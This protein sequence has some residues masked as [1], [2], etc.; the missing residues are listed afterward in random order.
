MYGIWNPWIFNIFW[1]I[2]SELV[3]SKI[4]KIGIG[5]ISESRSHAILI[6]YHEVVEK[7]IPGW[8]QSST[9]LR[10]LDPTCF[11]PR[12][13]ILRGRSMYGI[14][15]PWTFNFFWWISSELVKIQDYQNWES[16]TDFTPYPMVYP[17]P[18]GERGLTR[19]DKNQNMTSL[20]KKRSALIFW[21]LS[22]CWREGTTGLLI[23]T[24]PP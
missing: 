18:V 12:F 4:T 16:W 8:K 6:F 3:K 10:S 15:N 17:P 24:P 22:P 13:P 14:W 2:S 19:G 1:W 11:S 23:L 20:V 5:E 21:V 9:A 7:T